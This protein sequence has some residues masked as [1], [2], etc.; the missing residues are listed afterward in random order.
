MGRNLVCDMAGFFQ[1]R[2]ATLMDGRSVARNA[3]YYYEFRDA[4]KCLQAPAML[5]LTIEASSATLGVVTCGM[6]VEQGQLRSGE[7]KDETET[8][9][10]T[11]EKLAGQ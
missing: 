10:G 8:R 3:M 6:S 2:A 9:L 5:L 7:R 11:R 1:I 4:I